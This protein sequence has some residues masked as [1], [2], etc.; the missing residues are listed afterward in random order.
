MRP[1]VRMELTDFVSA[2]VTNIS[3]INSTDEDSDF[4]NS[5]GTVIFLYTLIP[6]IVSLTVVGNTIVILA[7]V[8]DQRL[9]TQSNLFL[10]NLAICD[11]FIG[12]FCIPVSA[13][14]SLTGKWTLGNILCKLWL[15]ADDLM[16]TASVFNIVLISYDRFLS[17]TL[18]VTYHF[19]P[20]TYSYTILKFVAVWVVSFL[21]N[22]PALLFWEYVDTER[23]IPEGHCFPIYNH[24]IYFLLGVSV[25]DFFIPLIS[26]TYFNMSIYWSIRTQSKNKS[27]HIQPSL[28]LSLE[29]EEMSWGPDIVSKTI[30]NGR[31]EN[32]QENNKAI[33][34]DPEM[35]RST[36]ITQL[37]QNTSGAVS[38]SMHLKKLSRDKKVA[39]SLTLL[40]CIFVVCWAPFKLEEIICAVFQ[41]ECVDTFWTEISS[42]LLWMNSSINPIIYPLCHKSFRKALRKMLHLFLQKIK[43]Q[44]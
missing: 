20:K 34:T 12:A 16:C 17:I 33:D 41:I 2:G 36:N 28:P 35:K 10:L 32:T 37:S 22:G 8:I 44:T 42:W 31:N 5:P 38:P 21:L 6:T 43:I 18:A 25:F 4:V 11:F 26:I 39:K 9:R 14:Y 27:H 13:S 40:I 30:N 19:H 15:I 24:N 1:H 7:F 3:I 29:K 23:L